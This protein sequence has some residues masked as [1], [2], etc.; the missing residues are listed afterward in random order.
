MEEKVTGCDD[1]VFAGSERDMSAT[2]LTCRHPKTPVDYS[3]LRVRDKKVQDFCP[4]MEEP[5]TIALD[6]TKPSKLEEAIKRARGGR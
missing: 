6:Y 1:C 2:L 5:I 4:L 3:Y